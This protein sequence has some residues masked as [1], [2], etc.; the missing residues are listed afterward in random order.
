MNTK[1]QELAE[2]LY[3]EGVERGNSEAESI[4]AAATQQ[5]ADIVAKAKEEAA[6]IMA[7][8][9]KKA[10]ELDTNTRTELKQY[11]SQSVNALKSEIVNVVC[12][13]VLKDTVANAVQSDNVLGEFLVNLASKWSDNQGM[14]IESAEAEKLTKYFAAH[15]KALLDKG[16]TINQVNGLKTLVTVKPADGSYKLEF[17]S[18]EFEK[19][20]KGFLRP[21]LI[22]MLF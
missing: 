7:T 17:G 9:Q 13:S 6:S 2:K 19:Y 21:Q 16:V 22:E 15:A 20:F 4:I 12:A 18:E 8:A 14:V 1:V 10:Q 3:H 11:A 5:A